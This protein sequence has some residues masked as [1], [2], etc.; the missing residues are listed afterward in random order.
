[1]DPRVRYLRLP[2][3]QV[4]VLISETAEPLAL[5]GILLNVINTPFDLALMTWRVGLRWQEYR[6][7]TLLGNCTRYSPIAPLQGSLWV[8][9]RLVVDNPVLSR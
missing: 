7:V 3:E 2:L 1:M 4:T 6:A 9:L 8:V 5:Q